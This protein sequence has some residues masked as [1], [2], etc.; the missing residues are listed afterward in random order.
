MEDNKI[1]LSE[2]IILD[3]NFIKAPSEKP[4]QALRRLS[5]TILKEKYS[6]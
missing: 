1:K 5:S 4:I 3:S 6:S 2:S